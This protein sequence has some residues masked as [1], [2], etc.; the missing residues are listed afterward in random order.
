M[1]NRNFCGCIVFVF[2]LILVGLITSVFEQHLRTLECFKQATTFPFR[3]ISLSE[4]YVSVMGDVGAAYAAKQHDSRPRMGSAP[5]DSVR[6][7]AYRRAIRRALQH[8]WTWYRGQILTPD[9]VAPHHLKALSFDTFDETP[10]NQIKTHHPKGQRFSCLSWNVSGLSLERWDA[11]Q[12]WILLQDLDLICLQETHWKHESQ[13]LTSHYHHIHS[14]STSQG[15]LLVMVS[16][17]LCSFDQVTWNSI[18]PGRLQH[19]RITLGGRALDLIHCYQFVRKPGNDDNRAHLWQQL[20]DVLST[21]PHRN[22]L[23][24]TGDWNTSLTRTSSLVGLGDYHWQGKRITG[25]KATD[26]NVFQQ[27]LSQNDLVV[28][29]SWNATDGPTFRHENGTSRI[30]FI[31][32]RR[33]HSDTLAR[34]TRALPQMPLVPQTGPTHIPLIATLKTQWYVYRT[35]KVT[36]WTI[37]HRQQ[38]RQHWRANDDTWT[39]I[40][41]TIVQHLDSSTAQTPYGLSTLHQV[42]NDQV[43]PMVNK[44]PVVQRPAHTLN[45]FQQFLHCRQA[46]CSFTSCDLKSLFH[47]WQLVI[48]QQQA[49]RTMRHHSKARRKDQ[50]QQLMATARQAANANDQFALFSHIR[51]IT[52]KMPRMH[53][54]L[55]GQEGQLLDPKEAAQAIADWLTQLYNDPNNNSSVDPFPHWSFDEQDLCRSFLEFE[56]TKALDPE[57][58]PSILWHH[59]AREFA[60]A[61]HSSIPHWLRST[62]SLTGELWGK[63]TLHFLCKPK[64]KCDSPDSL[65]PIALLEPSGKAIMGILAREMMSETEDRLCSLPQFAYMRNRGCNDAI[66]RAFNLIDR[67]M[68]CIHQRQYKRHPTTLTQSR[69]AVWGGLIVSLDLSKAFDCVNRS[70]LYQAMNDFQISQHCIDMI[71]LIYNHSSYSFTHRGISQSVRTHKGIRQGCKAAP[72]LWLIYLGH[73]MY[74]LAEQTGWD[75]LTIFNTV[76]ADDWLTH[77]DFTD[78][79]DLTNHIQNIGYLFDLLLD[80]NL[81]INVS[82]T[83][84]ILRAT[85]PAL[86]QLNRRFLHRTKQGIFLKIPRR[87]GEVTL[88]RLQSQQVYLGVILKFGSYETLSIRYRLQC[89]RNIAFMLNRWLRGRHGLTTRQK[90]KLWYQCVFSCLAHG[91]GHTGL[92]PHNLRLIDS[93]CMQQLRGIMRQPAHLTKINHHDFLQTN[94]ITDPLLTLQH[95]LDGILKREHQRCSLLQTQDIL[96]T[97]TS[98][99][100]A[101]AYHILT[102]FIPER[103]T[104][105]TDIRPIFECIYCNLFFGDP[106]Q[107]RRHCTRVHGIREG[108]Y[109]VMNPSHDSLSGVPTCARCHKSFTSWRNRQRH[110]EAVC[111]LSPAQDLQ[112]LQEFRAHQKTFARFAGTGLDNLPAQNELLTK[113]RNRCAVC[114]QFVT[115]DKYMK[116][117]WKT[118]HADAFITHDELY[119]DLVKQGLPLQKEAE[120]CTFCAKATKSVHH[121][122]MLLRNLAMLGASNDLQDRPIHSTPDRLFPCSHCDRKFLT[123]NGLQMH[124]QKKHEMD[125]K[126]SIAFIVERDCLPRAT[127]CAHCGTAF[128]CMSSVERHIRGGKCKEFN[129]DLPVCTLLSTHDRLRELVTQDKLADILLDEELKELLYLTCGLCQQTFRYRGSLG[130]HFVSRHASVVSAA[131][132]SVLDLETKHRGRGL[133]CFCPNGHESKSRAH[134][135]VIFQQYAMLRHYVITSNQATAPL[136]PDPTA[137]MLVTQMG[138]L[139]DADTDMD[140]DDMDVTTDADLAL[141]LQEQITS[142]EAS[143]RSRTDTT[144]QV[145]ADSDVTPAIDPAALSFMDLPSYSTPLRLN[146]N[147][148]DYLHDSMLLNVPTAIYHIAK[149]DYLALWHDVAALHFMSRNCVC[150]NASF[151]FDEATSHASMHW[152][153]ITMLPRQAYTECAKQ[154]MQNFCILPWYQNTPSHQAILHQILLVRLL[155]EL[156][157]NGPGRHRDVGDLERNLASQRVAEGLQTA[158]FTGRQIQ[159]QIKHPTTSG[160]TSGRSRSRS[161]GART[162]ESHCQ[163]HSSARGHTGS[164][165]ATESV[166]LAHE[167][168]TRQS[169]TFNDGK[170]S[171]LARRKSQDHIIEEQSCIIDDGYTDRE[172]D[173]TPDS[174]EGRGTSH[175]RTGSPYSHR[176]WQMPIFGMAPTTTSLDSKQ[177]STA[178]SISPVADPCRNP[179][180]PEGPNF[181]ATVPQLA[182]DGSG[183]GATGGG[184]VSVATH[185]VAS[186]ACLHSE[187]FISQCLATRI[188]RPEETDSNQISFGK[189][190]SNIIGKKRSLR[191]CLNKPHLFCWLNAIALS[192]GWLGLTVA[193]PHELWIENNWMF[194]EL[195]KFTPMPLELYN[196]DATFTALLQDWVGSHDWNQQQDA[197]E[198]LYY[199]LPLL[200]PYFFTGTWVPKW[201]ADD[202]RP[203]QETLG[204]NDVRGD[205]FAPILMSI[206]LQVA[207][208]T[209]QD[210][211]NYWHD[212]AGHQRTLIGIPQ[213]TC[214]YLDRLQIEPSPHKDTTAVRIPSYVRMPCHGAGQIEWIAFDVVAVTYHTGSSFTSGHWQTSIWQG[215]PYQRWLHYD[216]GSLPQ[217]GFHLSDH[218]LKNW[219]LVWIAY[220]PQYH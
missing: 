187:D 125:C 36:G 10:S 74:K 162:V 192:L 119:A 78:L 92:T 58:L 34:Q 77:C 120:P 152:S 96:C 158:S 90:V 189:T 153:Q 46:L 88:I 27:L 193:Y 49:R 64:K 97:W 52:P 16:K 164:T 105:L 130:N 128:N 127:A 62:P 113:F 186:S 185:S 118:E 205:R 137:D 79:S 108:A 114:N 66:S 23:L 9:L 2:A 121:D 151:S 184:G 93:W 149:G 124:L 170:E 138:D 54:R 44:L 129:P 82:K 50:R 180:T 156:W 43:G 194:R 71:Q 11:L 95:R 24:L 102:Q 169:S 174:T 154:F 13:W 67:V 99:R 8:G 211:I 41:E 216:D 163:A 165:F 12:Q 199:L 48:K 103:R 136:T 188:D 209:L 157:S 94:R 207:D 15:G 210:F 150:C 31:I 76:F 182:E 45:G 104:H 111:L 85:G 145:V 55:R 22:L 7:R 126:G 122:C 146:D 19:L 89:A 81:C 25:P 110:I 80:Y 167:S 53:I 40:N 91:L 32:T 191:I 143:T 123:H 201:A 107:L 142:Q 61:I 171:E 20:H 116:I 84:A 57:F 73:L 37:Q 101:A 179:R 5:T 87:N 17:R 148:M 70:K 212:V 147:V 30:D 160:P 131:R 214:I 202:P 59:N 155:V 65:R 206:C 218:I 106:G 176:R 166:H 56:G 208:Y 175:G 140:N 217:V 159:E 112:N 1:T 197:V 14:G 60:E 215:L 29:N 134:R 117:H 195:T 86:S 6:K 33:V 161:R 3:V 115:S 4:G 173:Q 141:L 204:E 100:T 21:L 178:G 69:T 75:W 47:S 26:E 183:C 68:H 18:I 144:T 190:S 213:G 196:G 38:L 133:K 181:S 220:N 198:F 139:L 135:C 172:G 39:N 35:P 132:F 28:L 203:F 219:A 51:R 177:R 42:L 63:G 168:R 98:H 72:C 83:V 200:A 109:R